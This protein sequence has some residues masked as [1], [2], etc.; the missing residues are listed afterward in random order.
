MNPIAGG[1]KGNV[2]P[3]L[4]FP[5]S[6]LA[7]FCDMPHACRQAFAKKVQ[8]DQE[9]DIGVVGTHRE[10]RFAGIQGKSAVEQVGVQSLRTR[11]DGASRVLNRGPTDGKW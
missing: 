8:V 9:I 3:G 5:G 2:P 10:G 6:A 4:R 1:H 7:V 11:Q